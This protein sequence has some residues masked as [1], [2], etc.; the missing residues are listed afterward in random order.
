MTSM[1]KAE[2]KQLTKALRKVESDINRQESALQRS[3]RKQQ[4]ELQRLQEGTHP[5]FFMRAKIAKQLLKLQA[6]N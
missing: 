2:L 6:A 4:A 1:Q 3:I 5:A